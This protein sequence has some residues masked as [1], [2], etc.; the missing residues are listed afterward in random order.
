VKP[1][2]SFQVAS[3]SKLAVLATLASACGGTGLVAAP[4]EQEPPADATVVEDPD[5]RPDATVV[6]QDGSSSGP[7]DGS[8]DVTIDVPMN[9]ASSLA[10]GAFCSLPGSVI[11]TADGPTVVPGGPATPDMTWMKVPPGYCTHYFAQIN[12]T[13]Q[14]RFAPGGDL[15]V[16]S[17]STGTP[18]GTAFQGLGEVVVLPDDNHDG[19]SDTPVAF[20]PNAGAGQPSITSTQ[21]LMFAN[22]YFY[23]EDVDPQDASTFYIRRVPFRPGDRA[24]SGMV[25]TVTTIGPNG[26]LAVPQAPD[27][28]SKVLDIA[29]DGT[30]YVTNGSDQGQVCYS[31]SSPNSAPF[32]AIFKINSDGT[33]T[34]VERGFR[35]PIALKCEANHNVC[36][37]VELAL[38]GS[39]GV[40][41]EK[42]VP[43]HAGDDWGFPCCATTGEP[44]SGEYYHDT[45]A[46]P[47]C[48]NVA[49]ENVSFVVGHTPFGIDFEPGKWPPPWTGRVFSVLHGVVGSWE[50]ARIVAI[51]LDPS[52][53]NLL[54]ASELYSDASTAQN[55][56][57]FA[58][59][60]YDEDAGVSTGH[61]RPS[62]IAFAPDGR[63]FIG[64]DYDGVIAWIAPVDLVR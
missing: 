58:T 29:Q 31:P 9:D 7:R 10:Q 3:W 6:L 55:M 11:W 50:G 20:F 22:G 59:G 2:R 39:E 33:I 25:Q 44:Y 38:D 26:P 30:I 54:P 34:E 46:V 5:A 32:G 41:R 56:L 62:A 51:A 48:S 16:A 13:R 60:W 47:D 43:V 12:H 17:P 40:G 42:I 28:W 14:M 18:G 57:E 52:T 64:D 24:P 61:G 27:H 8:N 19:V 21:G 37:A 53:G 15:F 4:G 35:N 36:L 49:Q 45:N 63:A 1:A 23:Y